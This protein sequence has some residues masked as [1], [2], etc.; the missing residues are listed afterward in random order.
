MSQHQFFSHSNGCAVRVIA[1]YDHPLD[2][3]FLHVFDANSHDGDSVVFASL[4]EPYADWRN[5]RTLVNKLE[6]LNL[7]VPR[8]LLPA[9]VKDQ[10]RRAR[11]KIVQ[12]YFGWAPRTTWVR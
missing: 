3:L 10:R 6:A 1:G 5:P 8:S 9:I 11:N 12:H 4:Y 2:E 7:V